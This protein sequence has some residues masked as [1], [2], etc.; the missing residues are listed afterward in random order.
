MGAGVGGVAVAS[1]SCLPARLDVLSG[2]GAACR[3]PLEPDGEG[4]SAPR[5]SRSVLSVQETSVLIFLL[6]P[7]G[8]SGHW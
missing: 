2:V 5:S 4:E 1:P 7:L 8:Y 3:G 6:C